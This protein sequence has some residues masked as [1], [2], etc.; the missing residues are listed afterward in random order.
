MTMMGTVVGRITVVQ[1]SRFRLSR[2][3]GT[4]DLF[5][6]SAR[7]PL[8]PQDLEALAASSARVAVRYERARDRIAQLVLD[9]TPLP[10]ERRT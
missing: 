10:I 1:E 4:S 2:D 8:E 3:D 7:A 6:L 5:L 9:V